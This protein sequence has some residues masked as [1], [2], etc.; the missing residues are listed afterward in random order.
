[1]AGGRTAISDPNERGVVEALSGTIIEP[2]WKMKT[3]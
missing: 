3:S 2:A 1:M